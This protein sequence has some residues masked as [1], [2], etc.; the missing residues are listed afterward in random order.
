MYLKTLARNYHNNITNINIDYKFHFLPELRAIVNAG[1]DKQDGDGSVTVNPLSRSGY[2][3]NPNLPTAQ[4]GSYS[5]TWYHNKN[6]NLNAQLNYTKAFGKLNVDLLGGYEY[7]QF[8][9]QNYYSGNK[10]L[11]GLGVNEEVKELENITTS[12]YLQLFE[13][14]LEVIV[15]GNIVELEDFVF[16]ENGD[17]VGYGNVMKFLF[18]KDKQSFRKQL[19]KQNSNRDSKAI[20]NSFLNKNAN[21]EV[22]E[23]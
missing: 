21:I 23:L 7:Q 12:V 16:I 3:T 11:F 17:F 5:E 13:D 6:Q 19:I 14:N 10:N 18:H 8:D 1:M 9:W 15:N 22:I 4:I 2:N 20:I